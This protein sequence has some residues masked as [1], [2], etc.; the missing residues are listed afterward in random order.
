MVWHPGVGHC[1]NQHPA[2]AAAPQTDSRNTLGLFGAAALVLTGLVSTERAA[3]AARTGL[4]VYLFLA[5]MM[6]LAELARQTG[7]FVMNYLP[8]GLASGAAIER[9]ASY[10]ALNH[11]VLWGVDLGPN[12][13]VT[14]SLATILWLI[15]MRRE[16]IE[17]TGWQFFK[18]GA[19]V[20]PVALVFALLTAGR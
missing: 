8:I 5:G 2:D 20:M 3:A 13:S 11:A 15:A 7:V 1:R 4:D 12:L 17:I 10:V 9:S 19:V 6:L 18:A 16:N 14:G